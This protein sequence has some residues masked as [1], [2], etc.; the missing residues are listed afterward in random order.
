[1]YADATSSILQRIQ[2]VCNVKRGLQTVALIQG[3][4]NAS[5]KLLLFWF[6]YFCYF[7][8]LGTETETVCVGVTTS[9]SEETWFA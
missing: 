1:M 3:S 2:D 5:R 4:G 7:V 8:L 6:S 9:I